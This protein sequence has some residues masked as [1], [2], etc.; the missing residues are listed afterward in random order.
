MKLSKKV[1]ALLAT[2]ITI[3]SFAADKTYTLTANQLMA[4]EN[5]MSTYW[6]Q[7][8]VEAKALYLQGYKLATKNLAQ[9]IKKHHKKP[10]AIVLDID[11]TVLDNSQYQAQNI[12]DGTG[13]NP[14]TWDEW[15]QLG[16][17]KAVPGA[18]EFLRFANKNKVKIFFIS[19]RDG[20][21]VDI[22]K[23]NLENEGIPVQSTKNLLFKNL[24]TKVERMNSVKKH[25][26]IVMLFGDNI[27]DFGDFSKTSM[28]DREKKLE[29]VKAEFGDKFIIFPNPMYGSFETTIYK[30]KNVKK[31]AEEQMEVKHNLLKGYK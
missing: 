19:D 7:T 31:S 27:C 29:E 14:K 3:A 15:V 13:F 23:K 6:Y 8:S 16:K 9:I 18:K 30:E 4:R 5:T 25:Y 22:T 26:D 1:F 10:I 28:A 24:G 21:Q 20:N 2:T 17:A 12:K 11:E